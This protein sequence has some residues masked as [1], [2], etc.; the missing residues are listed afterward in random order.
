[1]IFPGEK[2]DLW[3]VEYIGGPLDGLVA[4]WPMAHTGMV[5]RVTYDDG[6]SIAHYH[7]AADDGTVRFTGTLEHVEPLPVANP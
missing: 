6:K 2:D 7:H 1:M 5:L 4:G 3:L